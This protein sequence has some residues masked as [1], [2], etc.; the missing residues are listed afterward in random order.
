V[1]FHKAT[2]SGGL[3]GEIDEG[4]KTIH[5]ACPDGQDWCHLSARISLDGTAA[6]PFSTPMGWFGDLAADETHV[7]W[8][9]GMVGWLVYCEARD[10][11]GK[12]VQAGTA[13]GENTVAVKG[14]YVF[15]AAAKEI[16]RLPKNGKSKEKKLANEEDVFSIAANDEHVYFFAPQKYPKSDLLRV[17]VTGGRAETVIKDL[18]HPE[19]LAVDGPFVFWSTFGHTQNGVL[20][21]LD[22]KSGQVTALA[23]KQNQVRALTVDDAYVYWQSTADSGYLIQRVAR[24]GGAPQE[25]ALV[26]SETWVRNQRFGFAAE[27][28]YVYFCTRDKAMRVK[29][30]G[31]DPQLL[32]TLQGDGDMISLAVTQNHLY[33]FATILCTKGKGLCPQPEF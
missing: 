5:L 18:E 11:P 23:E 20:S 13:L 24:E 28:E 19:V 9:E 6:E 30:S 12:S 1:T 15:V 22:T 25:L 29:K 33:V 27:G 26:E 32:A 8:A 4:P 10:A 16:V 7:C 3:N 2:Q 17:P 14:D 21:V 31:G